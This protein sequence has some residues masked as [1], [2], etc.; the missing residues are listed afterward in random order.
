M[1]ADPDLQTAL[2]AEIPAAEPIV[3]PHRARLDAAPGLGIPAHVTILAPF[4]PASRLAGYP[5]YGGR[6]DDVVPHLTVV[7]SGPVDEMRSAADQIAGQL[8]V[9]GR[10]TVVTL[11]AESSR[12]QWRTLVS[13][14]LGV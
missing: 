5:P 6:F 12:G 4:A 7:E 11:M 8:P 13:F 10:V 9:A 1:D 2:I 3:G 14:P